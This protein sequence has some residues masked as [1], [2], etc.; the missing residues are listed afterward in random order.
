MFAGVNGIVTTYRSVAIHI[1]PTVP[2][3][4]HSRAGKISATLGYPTAQR[5][6]F[7]GIN[8][9]PEGVPQVQTRSKR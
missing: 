4:R 1:L 7:S 2:L 3:N 6:E 5:P 9:C 8:P